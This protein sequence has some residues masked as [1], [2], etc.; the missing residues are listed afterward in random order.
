MGS[1]IGIRD[2]EF[3]QGCVWVSFPHVLQID[4]SE[5]WPASEFHWVWDSR[6]SQTRPVWRKTRHA[7]KR[8]QHSRCRGYD[9]FDTRQDTLTKGL[10]VQDSEGT[11]VKFI[12]KNWYSRI[13]SSRSDNSHRPS[14]EGTWSTTLGHLGQRIEEC[15]LPPQPFQVCSWAESWKDYTYAVKLSSSDIKNL[16]FFLRSRVCDF[17]WSLP[18]PTGNPHLHEIVRMTGIFNFF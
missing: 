11:L 7:H 4:S 16:K 1:N 12:L 3:R 17:F 18:P 8:T 15:I 2:P 9:Q 13:L 5:T 10:S 14:D 6:V